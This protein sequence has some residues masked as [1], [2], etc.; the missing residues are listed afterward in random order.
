MTPDHAEHWCIIE[1]SRLRPSYVASLH[2]RTLRDKRTYLIV[3]G[4]NLALQLNYARGLCIIFN[5]ALWMMQKHDG[6]VDTS[7]LRIAFE[8]SKE[9]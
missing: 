3:R 2:A 5:T 1:V 8:T 4:L 6:Q 9:I 7:F